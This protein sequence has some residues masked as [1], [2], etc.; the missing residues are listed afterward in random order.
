MLG[1][2]EAEDP[3]EPAVYG[4][5]KPVQSYNPFYLQLHHWNVIIKNMYNTNG[6]KNKL[7]IPF[8]GPGWAPGKP[9]LGYLD[10]IPSV[11]LTNK[12]FMKLMI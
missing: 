7:W 11:S 3:K 2:F 10:D 4:L 12:V 1:T 8:K 9:R 5:V 6:W